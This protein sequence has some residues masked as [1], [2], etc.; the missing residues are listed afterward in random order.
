MTPFIRFWNTVNQILRSHDL[1]EMHYGEARDWWQQH[2]GHWP[3]GGGYK[4]FAELNAGRLSVQGYG[5][6]ADRGYDTVL[7]ATRRSVG[8]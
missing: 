7:G 8:K 4:S 5:P 6:K 1:P 3:D 2:Q